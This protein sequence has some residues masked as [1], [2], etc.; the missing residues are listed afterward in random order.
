MICEASLLNG[1]Y[2]DHALAK[3]HF[4]KALE[5]EDDPEEMENMFENYLFVLEEHFKEDME[6]I[7]K[8]TVDKASVK[9]VSEPIVTYGKKQSTS[10]A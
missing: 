9:G 2:N 10:V 7:I 6:D 5:F 4:E 1:Y 8:V 3:I